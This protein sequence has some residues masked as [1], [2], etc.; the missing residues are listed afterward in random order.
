MPEPSPPGTGAAAS[1]AASEK[2]RV[3]NATLREEIE[4]LRRRLAVAETVKLWP[5]TP[6]ESQAGTPADGS[7]SPGRAP[8]PI[9]GSPQSSR[10]SSNRLVVMTHVSLAFAAGGV[11][12]FADSTWE[13]DRFFAG[14]LYAVGSLLLIFAVPALHA[15]GLARHVGYKMFQPFRGGVRFVVLQALSWAFYSLAVV[16]LIGAVLYGEHAVGLLSS[17]GVLGIVSQVLMASS[18]QTF[19]TPAGGPEAPAAPTP[20]N[21]C[22]VSNLHSGAS[23]EQLGDTPFERI[24]SDIYGDSQGECGDAALPDTLGSLPQTEN[25]MDSFAELVTL[26]FFLI[27]IMVGLSGISE[28]VG[29]A[30]PAALSLVITLV[31]VLLTH[32]LGGKVL[33]LQGWTFFQPFAGGTQFVVL[34]GVTWMLFAVSVVCQLAF[35]YVVLYLGIKLTVGLMHVGGVAA[36]LSEVLCVVSFKYFRGTQKGGKFLIKKSESSRIL[37]GSAKESLRSSGILDFDEALGAS[38]EDSVRSA[39]GDL[40]TPLSKERARR[41]VMDDN[42]QVSID[43]TKESWAAFLAVTALWNVWYIPIATHIF[44]I[45]F[46]ALLPVSV[47]EA[48][49]PFSFGIVYTGVPWSQACNTAIPPLIGMILWVANFSAMQTLGAPRLVTYLMFP[50]WFALAA[51]YYV[52]EDGAFG[53]AVFVTAGWLLYSLT[54]LGEPEMGRRNRTAQKWV[55][56][57]GLW[58]LLCSYFAGRVL[59]SE[60]LYDLIDKGEGPATK[61]AQYMVG[62]QPHGIIPSGMVWGMRCQEWRQKLPNFR[63]VGLTASIIHFVPLMRDFAQWTGI[64]E[65]S[66]KTVIS[67][68]EE[69]LSPIVVV[70]G[71]SEMFHSRS[72]D[73]AIKIVRHHNGFF[74]IAQ[75]RQV[76]VMPVFAFG[77]TKI[78]DNVD[79]PAM[80]RWTKDRLGFP[81]PFFLMGRW[82]L[83]LPRR[84]QVILAVGAP[85]SPS[86][87]PTSPESVNDL[88]MRYY[89]AVQDLFNEFKGPAG[90]DDHHLHFVDSK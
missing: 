81:I 57:T 8:P 29:H 86:T 79:L 23:M 1:D 69:G 2:L 67:T 60:K 58:D 39:D 6:A 43:E 54:Y 42:V 7:L 38:L 71:Q 31:A 56:E 14:V 25:K 45:G 46:P 62:Y 11:F 68:L 37:K 30:V 72:R 15:T 36:V 73:K 32:G 75:E 12:V 47:A 87:E 26:N 4:S 17:G 77:E 52:R 41:K 10:R 33:R 48:L 83:P 64:R 51:L 22:S 3:E 24:S 21:R 89:A 78:Y 88:K 55:D 80:Q 9:G 61:D 53:T 40:L 65:V 82:G 16:A 49:Q 34:Q 18:L 35:L 59:L 66:R 5:T 20:A 27:V 85:L 50:P 74:K 63:P 19:V 84:K 44:T 76:P 28:L 13:T 70:G 90:Y